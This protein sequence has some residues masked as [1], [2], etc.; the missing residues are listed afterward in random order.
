[1]QATETPS[2]NAAGTGEA[3][4]GWRLPTRDWVL[5]STPQLGNLTERWIEV[6]VRTRRTLDARLLGN[7]IAAGSQRQP[8]HLLA[9][10]RLDV[11]VAYGLMLHTRGQSMRWVAHALRERAPLALHVHFGLYGDAHRPLAAALH[12]PLV[13]SFYGADATTREV[14]ESP[15]WRRRYA[16]MFASGD[17]FLAEGPAMAERL[18]RLG[19]LPEK[20][21]VV[22]LPADAA[23][24]ES[25]R[26]ARA[27]RLRVVMGGRFCEKKGFDTGIRAFARAL[28]DHPD[29]ELLLMG[30]GELEGELRR[31][32]E[33]EGIT[34]RVEFAGRLP[35]PEFMGRLST[36]HLALHPSRTARDGDSEGGAPVTLIEGEWLG[37]PALVSD[38]DDLPFVA[39][40]DGSVTLPPTD[41]DAW[42]EALRALASDPPRLERMGAAA[43][44]FARAHHSP[45]A[46]AGAREEIYRA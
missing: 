7:A 26:R 30:G 46:N 28:S 13:T 31:L 9:T 38:H 42:A 24:L 40:P 12:R 1:M 45:E 23:G 25:C 2:R 36:A 39:A 22:R 20:V 37:V 3:A 15:T 16:R 35:F 5:H 17:A 29:A 18:V 21:H 6:Q 4:A 11:R 14:I 19:C 43:E 41:V 33:A 44:E 10:D 34:G 27:E 8:Y 32:V